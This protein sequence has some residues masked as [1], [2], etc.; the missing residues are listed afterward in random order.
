MKKLGFFIIF[1]V[2][3][4]FAPLSIE[5]YEVIPSELRPGQEGIIELTLSNVQE[6][7]TATSVDPVENVAVYY[8]TV[9]GMEFKS[10]GPTQVGTL[11]GGATSIVT[12][13]IKV[14]TT[15]K[16]GI[17]SPSLSIRQDDALRTRNLVIPI[18]VT[19]PPILTLSTDKQTI[20]STDTLNITITN[21]GGE[22]RLLTIKI[23]DSDDFSFIGT[24]QIFAGTIVGSASII[25]SIDSRNA[26]EGVTT[27]PFLLNYHQENGDTASELKEVSITVKKESTDIVFTQLE[28][29]ITSKDN[30]LEL[31]VRNTGQNL[32]DFRISLT[33]TNIQSKESD[34][35]GLGDLETNGE[36]TFDINVFAD[37]APGVHKAQ[38]KLMW[39]EEDVEK[40]E[41]VLVPITVSS[42]ADVAIFIDAKPEPLVP[43]QEYTLSV[44]VS[45]I[46]SYS[47]ENVE[48]ALDES[49]ILDIL[50]AQKSQYIGGLDNDDFSTVQYKVRIMSIEPG[51][52]PL[53]IYVKYK[54]SSG[55]WVE[56]DV[57]SSIVIRSASELAGSEGDNTLLY[58]AV[59]VIAAIIYWYYKKRKKQQQK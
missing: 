42:D 58:L 48:I 49:D 33:D 1:L 46:G 29:I 19:N 47:I 16:G 15:A 17:L 14:L 25:T 52:Y 44:L 50:N 35:I 53:T 7:S 37:V 22:A 23:N 13:P 57:I 5:S 30:F 26:D 39:V 12:I 56:K 31:T 3:L 59:V 27:I 55:I 34:E 9:Q 11:D 20:A 10:A 24:D 4:L 6:T 18:Q 38:F 51:S 41:E 40:E 2:G 43:G 21:H 45:N 36:K 32:E 8:S 54:D 28:P